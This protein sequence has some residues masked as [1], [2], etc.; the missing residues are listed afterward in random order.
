M[1]YID[2]DR[3]MSSDHLSNDRAQWPRA[4]APAQD[5]DDLTR[6]RIMQSVNRQWLL[7]RHPEPDELISAEHFELRES[8]VPK[9]ADG[10]FV[11]KTLVLGT[12]PA[13]RA[14]TL[15]KQRFHGGLAIG[16]VMRS[17][18][19]G[20]VTESKNDEYQ[21][22]DL[23]AGSVG[24]QDYSL[25]TGVGRSVAGVNVKTVQRVPAGIA[26]LELALG[27]LG[28]AGVTA[29]VGLCEVAQIRPGD[30][31]VVSAAAG[32]V[33][34]LAVQI[35]RI[36]GCRVVGIA[37]GAEK[38]RWL[39]ESLGCD[40]AIDYRNENL[41]ERLDACCPDGIDAFF[42]NVGGDTLEA[43]LQRI[44]VG[45]RVALCG[46]ISSEYDEE[47]A[48]GPAHYFKLLYQR[49]TMRGF[50]V[51]DY[52]DRFDAIQRA[53]VSWYEAGWLKATEE[54]V[55]GLENAPSAL[56]DLFL[57]K[58]RGIRLTRVAPDPER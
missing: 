31:V 40:A 10:E 11:V 57:G 44:N 24:W 14:Y 58:N 19:L 55:D 54:V 32:G 30:T 34:S 51:W 5:N 2:R 41:G 9:P 28:A 26:P 6:E 38:C 25:Q 56:A 29:Y 39:T 45:A 46:Y 4:S 52:V 7:A 50:V 8:A 12:S 16:E 22:G 3:A 1:I 27:T 37:G 33:G 20:V 21:P 48:P 53:L 18:G 43:V 42:D 47:P 36:H 23:L 13:Q 17:R 35:A 15:K 49:A